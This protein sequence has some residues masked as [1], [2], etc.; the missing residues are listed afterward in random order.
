[1]EWIKTSERL[2]E[3]DTPVFCIYYDG[4]EGYPMSSLGMI[5]K[6]GEWYYTDGANDIWE[7][8]EYRELW[9]CNFPVLWYPLPEPPKDNS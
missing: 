7:P 5:D 8:E 3:I 1:M 4:R 9:H 2:P 6:K